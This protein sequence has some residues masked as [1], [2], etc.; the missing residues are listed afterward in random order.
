MFL[1][2]V[3]YFKTFGMHGKIKIVLKSK[4]FIDQYYPRYIQTGRVM[5]SKDTGPSCLFCRIANNEIA[6]TELVFSNDDYA[7]FKDHK[8][9]SDHHY[10][11]V[12]KRHFGK[13]SSLNIESIP[14]IT[15]LEE[16]GQEVLQ[17]K[18]GDVI[19]MEEALLGFH[20]PICLVG[21]LHMHAIYPISSM[22]YIGRHIVFSK[23]LSFG[24][25]QMAINMIN[26]K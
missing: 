7:A 3:M 9:A 1:S 4:R 22:S 5:E 13:V 12:P 19:N 11:I 24:T 25:V 23:K 6:E 14:M 21:H 26:K 16:I 20:W 15:K 18:V 10:L 17:S 8:P 2:N